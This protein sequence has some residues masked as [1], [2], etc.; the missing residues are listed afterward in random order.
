MAVPTIVS[1]T[2]APATGYLTIVWSEAVSTVGGPNYITY[3]RNS[4]TKFGNTGDA[5]TGE[6]TTTTV[7]AMAS[8]SSAAITAGTLSMTAATVSTVVGS[9]P[10]ATITNQAV[11]VSGG[12]LC[13]VAEVKT[14]L[15]ITATTWDSLIGQMILEAEGM[16][17][18]WADRRDDSTGMVGTG[19]RWL[20]GVHTETL[21]GAL[22]AEHQLRYWPVTSVSSVTVVTSTVSST[23]VATN[24]YRID[25]DQVRVRFIG[26]WQVAWEAGLTPSGLYAGQQSPGPIETVYAYPYTQIT[27]TGGFTAGSVPASLKSAAIRLTAAMFQARARDG[28]LLSEKLGDYSYTVDPHAWAIYQQD[29]IENVLGAFRGFVVC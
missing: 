8:V 5:V 26:T 16:M 20:S 4:S 17:A 25:A 28:T 27:Y 23:T 11:T 7:Y 15:D 9:T 1:A 21:P 14:R 10:N 2:Y 13:T 22:R 24:L 18:D 3:Q 19:P 6:G 12:E 29:F